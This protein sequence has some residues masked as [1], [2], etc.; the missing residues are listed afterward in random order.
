M[1]GSKPVV[2]QK[3]LIKKSMDHKTKQKSMTV[4]ETLWIQRENDRSGREVREGRAQSKQCIITC[5]IVKEQIYS[6]KD[7][8]PHSHTIS[9][10]IFQ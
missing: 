6:L 8:E 3:V 1:D 4:K 5:E 7:G 10:Y 2:K 9:K